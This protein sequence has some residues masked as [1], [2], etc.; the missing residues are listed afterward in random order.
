MRPRGW[1]GPGFS[2][3]TTG[4]HSRSASR[5]WWSEEEKMN[6][7]MDVAELARAAREAAE[8]E[9]HLAEQLREASEQRAQ[10]EAA[11]EAQLARDA[12]YTAHLEKCRADFEKV[13]DAL[14]L[15]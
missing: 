7:P 13:A 2:S 12:A 6:R 4:P 8:R 10:A 15:R 3:I 9:I 1:H 11:T 14:M 5:T